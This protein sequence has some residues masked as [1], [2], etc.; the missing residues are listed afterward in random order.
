MANEWKCHYVV[1]DFELQ[2][3]IY[4]YV[5]TNTIRK[6]MNPRIPQAMIEIVPLQFLNKYG[7]GMK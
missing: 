5:L 4:F 7:F 1:S 6:G 3:H 2:S